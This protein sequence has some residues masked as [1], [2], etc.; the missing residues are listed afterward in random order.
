M[1][2]YE[3]ILCQRG[4]RP[5]VLAHVPILRDVINPPQGQFAPL[6]LPLLTQMNS[7]CFF[8]VRTSALTNRTAH[9]HFAEETPKGTE[10]NW[11]GV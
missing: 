8:L 5:L 9:C 7:L 6:T 4:T 3:R 2:A 10:G 11:I 1:S